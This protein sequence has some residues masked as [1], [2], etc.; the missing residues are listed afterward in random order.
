MTRIIAGLAG[1]IRLDVPDAG[2]RPTSER[3][4]ESLFGALE[5]TGMLDGTAVL[6]LY[7][8]SGA[9]GLESLSRGAASADLVER[10]PKAAATARRNAERVAKATGRAALVHASASARLSAPVRVTFRSRAPRPAL[11]PRRHRSHGGPE[12]AR[13][14]PRRRRAGHRRARHAI[15][16]SGLGRCRPSALREKAFGDTS[17]YWGELPQ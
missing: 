3:V 4:R 10:A 6:D 9:L 17:L 2:T 13:T 7:T 1:G 14:A 11:R 8:G 12:T 16:H 5:P 15:R